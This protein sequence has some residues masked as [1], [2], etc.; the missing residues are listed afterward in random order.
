MEIGQH[1]SQLHQQSLHELYDAIRGHKDYLHGLVQQ[2]QEDVA[3]VVASSRQQTEVRHI[4]T[5]DK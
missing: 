2:A 1:L 3:A 5:A 4:L